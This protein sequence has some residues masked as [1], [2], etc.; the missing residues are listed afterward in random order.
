MQ[1]VGASVKAVRNGHICR[2]IQI[3][4]LNSKTNFILHAAHRSSGIAVPSDQRSDIMPRMVAMKTLV[5]QAAAEFLKDLEAAPDQLEEFPAFRV[6]RQVKSLYQTVCHLEV[7]VAS[8][9]RCKLGCMG[10]Q[11]DGRTDTL[12]A[13]KGVLPEQLEQYGGV[14]SY[15]QVSVFDVGRN[16][17]QFVSLCQC[18]ASSTTQNQVSLGSPPAADCQHFDVICRLVCI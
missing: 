7:P 15:A 6:K 17:N 18:P 4:D 12:L 2:S 1:Q 11:L 3:T 8:I 16:F 10:P 9:L 13:K 14:R 5:D